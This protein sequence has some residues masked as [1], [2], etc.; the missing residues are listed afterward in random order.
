MSLLTPPTA[1]QYRVTLFYGPDIAPGDGSRLHCVFNVKKRSWKAGIQVAVE[2]R[3]DLVAALKHRLSFDS[4]LEEMLAPVNA[5][6]RREYRHRAQDL[7]VIQAC[8]CKLN[9]ALDDGL[10]QENAT[11]GICPFDDNL[12]EVLCELSASIKQQVLV[13]L[14]PASH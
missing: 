13:E 3:A 6:A 1:P 2:L 5:D 8:T 14:D 9:A 12:P 4:W 11:L 7:L 10:P